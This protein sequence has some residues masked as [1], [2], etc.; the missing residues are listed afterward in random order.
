M[1]CS[2]DVMALGAPPRGSSRQ[3]CDPLLSLPSVSRDEEKA[4]CSPSG[5]QRGARLSPVRVS[6]I[7]AVASPPCGSS[8]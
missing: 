6:W 5:L 1:P 3:S 2:T 7:V 8:R 4:M